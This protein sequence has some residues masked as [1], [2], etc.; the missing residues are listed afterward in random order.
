[1]GNMTD[2]LQKIPGIGKML[3]QGMEGAED[4]LKRTEAIIL[5]MTIKERRTPNLINGS[6]RRRIADGSGTSVQDVNALLK[7]FQKMKLMMKQAMK[8]GKG[9]KRGIMPRGP[10]PP[11]PGF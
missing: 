7:E 5:S 3:P 10:M 8:G 11:L 1:M 2:L 6:R 4:E 9:K